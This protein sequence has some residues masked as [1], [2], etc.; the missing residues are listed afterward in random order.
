M[1]SRKSKY[2][3]DLIRIGV[4]LDGTLAEPVWTPENPVDDI[5]DPIWENVE[6]VRAL[7]EKGYKIYIHTSRPDY[8]VELVEG[9]LDKHGIPWR[10]VDCGKKLFRAYIDDRAI[11]ANAESWEPEEHGL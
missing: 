3:S 6:K 1:N 5:G 8:Q 2:R 11:P 9:W 7:H 10:H 4:D